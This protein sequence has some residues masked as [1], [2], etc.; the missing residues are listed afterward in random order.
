MENTQNTIQQKLIMPLFF[1]FLLAYRW[2]N[3]R[4][5]AQGVFWAVMV[6]L[7]SSLNDVLTRFSGTRLDFLQVAFFRFFFST[8]T[9]LPVMLYFDR[10]SFITKRPGFQSLRAL[11]GY[12]AVVSWVA[13][14]SMTTLTIASI[15]A[16]TVGLFVLVM[17]STILR[18]RVGWQRV[19]ATI[20]G[21][22]GIIIILVA[23]KG[24]AA[25]TFS[26]LS[27]FDLSMTLTTFFTQ[28]N[29]GI[30]FVLVAAVLFA[31]SD[32][33]NK[34]MIANESPLTMLF[35]FAAGTTIIGIIPA[36]TVWQ[37]PE[38]IELFWLLCLGA[39]A[40]LILFCLLKAFAATDISALQPYRYVEIFF[41]TG[42][43]FLLFGEIPTILILAGAAII[44]PSTFTIAIYES[45][46]RDKS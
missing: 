18:E 25:L 8:L 32:I 40:N 30:V 44:I 11:L 24:E 16:Q 17:A 22:L 6:C 3:Q 31:A 38:A 37:A 29:I 14:V 15:M 7:V 1:P 39:G 36:L 27:S 4:G 12:G 33:M 34:I 20:T 35:Y 13:G 9:L 45:R 5:Y 19:M 46:N 42:F 28:S 23:P 43:G 10:S 41:A 26:T 21:M 2:V